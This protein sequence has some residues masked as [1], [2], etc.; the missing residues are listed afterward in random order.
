MY[1]ASSLPP[2]F[3]EFRRRYTREYGFKAT[4][5]ANTC[6]LP[7]GQ[8]SAG[9]AILTT[10]AP[11][12]LLD[13]GAGANRIVECSE[14]WGNNY[15][16]FD[17][18]N[19]GLAWWN[20]EHYISCVMGHGLAFPTNPT[21][22]MYSGVALAVSQKVPPWP[23]P[24]VEFGIDTFLLVY[25]K[26]TDGTWYLLEDDMT[27]SRLTPLAGVDLFNQGI[28]DF[29]TFRVEIY[30]KPSTELSV[31]IN[32]KLGAR[33]IPMSDFV[34]RAIPHQCAGVFITSGTNA[35]GRNF[36]DFCDMRAVTI[37]PD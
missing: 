21:D 15:E 20:S 33:V 31:F 22:T 12:L 10:N 30:Y 3:R 11:R 24:P 16:P 5:V 14:A 23:V 1:P 13:T 26:N 25:C 6:E 4:N 19:T 35:L 9:F 2:Y 29:R 18:L 27:A 32:G 34:N 17:R 7:G 28:G 8:K 37:M 36:C